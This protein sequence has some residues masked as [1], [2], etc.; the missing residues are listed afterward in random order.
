MP[1]KLNWPKPEEILRLAIRPEASI[2]FARTST[3]SGNHDIGEPQVSLEIPSHPDA[4]GLRKRRAAG[5][6]SRPSKQCSPVE[7]TQQ[8]LPQQMAVLR[9]SR[10]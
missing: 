4:A 1:K 10:S 3:W 5:R 9:L 7:P 2:A 8:P 6:L